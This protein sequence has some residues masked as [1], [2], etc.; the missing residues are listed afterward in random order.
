[1]IRILLAAQKIMKIKYSYKLQTCEKFMKIAPRIHN[2]KIDVV[3]PNL[4]SMILNLPDISLKY[5]L[6]QL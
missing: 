3:Y 5:L 1:M 4:Q 2:N 6:S